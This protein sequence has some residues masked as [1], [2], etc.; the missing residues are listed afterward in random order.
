MKH[1]LDLGTSPMH[2]KVKIMEVLFTG[3]INKKSA[4]DGCSKEMAKK[5]FQQLFLSREGGGLRLFIPEP[6]KGGNSNTGVIA[7]RFFK[8]SKI[9]AKILNISQDL[10]DSCWKLLVWLNETKEFVD[11]AEYQNEAERCF[12]YYINEFGNIYSLRS[13]VIVG[14]SIYGH[15]HLS[16]IASP[17]YSSYSEH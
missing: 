1:L 8:S 13:K 11:C 15:A 9:T 7:N 4:T 5:H 10:V 6:Q 16:T 14:C 3:A 12:D 2:M 17:L